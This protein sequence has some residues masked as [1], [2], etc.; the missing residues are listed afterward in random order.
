MVERGREVLSQQSH[1]HAQLTESIRG[2]AS[3]NLFPSIG[4]L[5]QQ[6][7]TL[8]NLDETVGATGVPNEE[9]D[10]AVEEIESLCMSCEEQVR[11]DHHPR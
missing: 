7:D 9:D 6:T 11:A 1:F 2:M 3:Q 10:Q 5:A 8:S 4:T